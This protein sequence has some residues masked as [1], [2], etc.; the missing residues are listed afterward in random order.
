MNIQAIP[1]LMSPAVLTE[2]KLEDGLEGFQRLNNPKQ[3]MD[4]S[5]SWAS[6]V[7]DYMPLL[8]AALTHNGVQS[9]LAQRTIQYFN[10]PITNYFMN[11]PLAVLAGSIAFAVAKLNLTP[12]EKELAPSNMEGIQKAIS[13]STTFNVLASLGMYKV[14]MNPNCA[15]D[16]V[17]LFFFTAAGEML[18]ETALAIGSIILSALLFDLAN[19]ML[20]EPVKKAQ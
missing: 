5:S 17:S 12:P 14:V 19:D 16:V 11:F 2:S 15:T 3:A 9:F 13:W 7:I 8:G 20:S 6:R 1:T 4:L 10:N 18:S